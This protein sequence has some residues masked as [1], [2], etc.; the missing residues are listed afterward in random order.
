[1]ECIVYARWVRGAKGIHGPTPGCCVQLCKQCPGGS[2]HGRRVR[3]SQVSQ[4]IGVAGASRTF[5]RVLLGVSRRLWVYAPERPGPRP[6]GKAGLAGAYADFLQ[7][8]S[9]VGRRLWAFF[10][11]ENAK[12]L[13]VSFHW[14][15]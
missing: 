2:R 14:K 9:G 11:R 13:C 7:V 10:L 8:L 12:S 15:G 5:L 1:M 4:V 3:A 6:V